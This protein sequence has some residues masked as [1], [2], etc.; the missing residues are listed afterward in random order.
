MGTT[1]WAKIFSQVGADPDEANRRFLERDQQ[2]APSQANK[3]ADLGEPVHT[4][5]RRQI[6][7]IAR[8]QGRLVVADR[9]YFIFLALLP[10]ILGALSLTVPGSTGFHAAGPHAGTPDESAQ[11]LALL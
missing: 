11:I 3:P 7:T 1:N 10:F 6:S 8:R 5:V 2:P 4:S 9:A